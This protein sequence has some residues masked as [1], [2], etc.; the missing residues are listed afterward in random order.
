MVAR[1]N[2]LRRI[3][4]RL[5]TARG[6]RHTY[7]AGGSQSIKAQMSESKSAS[8]S[9][10][11]LP[12]VNQQTGAMKRRILLRAYPRQLL[13]PQAHRNPCQIVIGHLLTSMSLSSCLANL[14]AA[15]IFDWPKVLVLSDIFGL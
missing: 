6:I 14:S 15:Q 1:T 9:R 13:C 7:S 12:G 3:R 11:Q 8:T 2:K 10:L 5:P 4:A